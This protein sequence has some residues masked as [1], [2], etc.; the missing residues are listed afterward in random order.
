MLPVSN[1]ANVQFPML[2]WQLATLVIGNILH[3]AHFAEN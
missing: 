1:V 2:N 3:F